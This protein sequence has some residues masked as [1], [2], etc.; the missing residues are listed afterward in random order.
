MHRLLVDPHFLSQ[1]RRFW[2]AAGA[3]ELRSDVDIDCGGAVLS[4]GFID[5][6]HN[7][8]FGVD[9][10]K[11]DLTTAAVRKVARGL[12]AHGVTAFVGTVIT[13]SADTYRAVLPLLGRRDA[14][15]REGA[16]CLGTHLEG[17]FMHP[18]KKGAHNP[19]HLRVPT[20]GLPDA[21]D[22]WGPDA[23][24]DARIVTLAPELPGC[25]ALT[26]AL[27]AHGI[28]VSMGHSTAT[29]K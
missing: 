22:V 7:G 17:P 26:Q 13:S 2:D 20:R 18:A 12:A 1:Q 29:A 4:P 11:P 19:L 25:L 5:V 3:G 21:L 28:V 10:S 6:Q 15:G 14:R 16:S 24:R 23:L 27:R 9:Y 8:A